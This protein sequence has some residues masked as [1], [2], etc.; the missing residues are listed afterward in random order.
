MSSHLVEMFRHNR[1][2]NLRIFD[3]CAGLDDE[4]LDS[5]APGT[6]GDARSTLIH[7]VAGEEVYVSVLTG[8]IMD[9]ADRL[10]PHGPFPGFATL[11]E[12]I[13]ATGDKLI[14]LAS[15]TPFDSV[16]Q[17]NRPG[18]TP[19]PERGTTVLIQAIHHAGEHRTHIMTVISQHSIAVPETDGWAYGRD[20]LTT[21]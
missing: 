14:E 8:Q 9:E 21:D 11:R 10:D 6:F 16:L 15:T 3:W 18:R 12:R 20:E 1:W 4:L 5:S 13:A 19:Y 7:L 17:A 2:A